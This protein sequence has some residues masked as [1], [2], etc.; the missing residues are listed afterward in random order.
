MK[1][2]IRLLTLIVLIFAF[3]INLANAQTKRT[4]S[5]KKGAVIGAIAGAGTGAVISKNHRKKHAAIGAVAG[6]GT[7]YIIGR[8]KDKK[9]A[10]I[11]K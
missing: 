6:A 2:I 7:G 9:A 5:R 4:S 11:Q 3:T 8:K 10:R 1:S